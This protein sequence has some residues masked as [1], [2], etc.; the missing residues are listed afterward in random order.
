MPLSPQADA[1]RPT[2]RQD[3]GSPQLNRG[4]RATSGMPAD[5]AFCR[6]APCDWHVLMQ[7]PAHV[8]RSRLQRRAGPRLQHTLLGGT[9]RHRQRWMQEKRGD[10]TAT[11]HAP[12]RV[13]CCQHA[14]GTAELGGVL[15]PLLWLPQHMPDSRATHK[16]SPA[17]GGA[18]RQV[19]GRCYC[20]LCPG[21][22]YQGVQ[23]LH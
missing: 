5:T 6:H 8:Q 20:Q 23:G 16:G 9:G 14:A 17:G 15:N 21:R 13:Q 22:K 1:D 11:S 3:K 18:R 2:I 12:L 19:R 4:T 7:A 10:K